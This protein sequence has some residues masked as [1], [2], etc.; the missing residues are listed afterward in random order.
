VL[1]SEAEAGSQEAVLTVTGGTVVARDLR[2]GPSARVGVQ[3]TGADT[4]LE[5]HGVWVTEATHRGVEVG[6]GA[7]LEATLLVVDDTRERA[8]DPETRGM[9]VSSGASATISGALL[10][11]NLRVG[12]RV[13]GEGASLRANDLGVVDSQPSSDGRFGLGLT[14]EFG[15]SVVVERALFEENRQ[16]GV[17]AFDA[18][19][20]LQLRDS[21]VRGTLPEQRDGAFGWGLSVESG[22]SAL[23]ERVLLARNRHFGVFA[24]DTET[25][26]ELRDA[27]VRDTLSRESDGS[28]GRGLFVEFGASAVVER[29]LFERN[30][31]TGISAFD[32]G[33]SL[34]LRQ[35]AVRDTLPQ[36]ADGALGLG[37]NVLFGASADVGR[38]LIERNRTIGV[39]VSDPGTALEL[40]DSV[41]RDT[42]PQ[43]LGRMFG[44]GVVAQVGAEAVVERVIIEGNREAGIDT[45][46]PATTLELRDAV[47]RDTLPR[48]S[49]GLFGLGLSVGLGAAVLVER[50]LVAGNR[51]RGVVATNPGTSLRLRDAAVCD[52]SGGGLSVE[53][54]ASAT[55]ERGLVERNRTFGVLAT[56]AGTELT[57]HDSVVRDTRS[58]ENDGSRGLGLAVQAGAAAVVERA[59]L[60]RNRAAGVSALDPGTRLELRSAVV[61]DSLPEEIDDSGGLGLQVIEGASAA[62]ESALVQGNRA[63]GVFVTGE[64]ATLELRDAVVSGTLSQESDGAFGRGL[65]VEDGSVAMVER[66]VV[67]ENRDIG[68]YAGNPNTM[69]DLR[70]A[71]VRDTLSREVDDTGGRGLTLE[72]GAAAVVERAVLQRNREVG[73]FAFGSETGLQ[74]RNVVVSE[75]QPPMCAPSCS[76]GPNYGAGLVSLVDAQLTATAFVLDTN[77]LCGVLLAEEG[78]VDLDNG[79]VSDHVT[80]VC[81]QVPGFDTGRLRSDVQYVGNDRL[82]E[83]MDLVLPTPSDA[84]IDP[85]RP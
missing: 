23:V 2:I 13:L 33:T 30:R 69:L 18:D 71:V 73:M 15:A 27:V 43:E 31:D 81:L 46:D 19:T 25:T 1:V 39:F 83:A 4:R 29:A 42:R 10:R 76:S 65:S 32:M 35:V 50:T 64:N 53:L 28:G 68:V 60:S 26:L 8:G 63:V 11:R 3:A 55:V 7:Q 41:V 22:A 78:E 20:L 57:L 34:E 59:L 72:L 54:G 62:V 74:L 5:L 14:V 58:R 79:L 52:T 17:S 44:R 24:A 51:D 37:L 38:S 85:V 36:E 12:V 40:R 67:E 75:T 82:I 66:V 61:R 84:V 77:D 47:V 9:E 48:E 16:V 80:A 70:D 49:D 6:S 45:L 56:D 21:V